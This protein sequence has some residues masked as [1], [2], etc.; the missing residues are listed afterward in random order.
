MSSKF[1]GKFQEQLDY[2]ANETQTKG[3]AINVEQILIGADLIM[4]K[5]LDISTI[6]SF[7]ENQEII[8]KK[9]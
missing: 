6:P 2:T 9:V 3:G 5:M 8:F 4:R 1:V 7:F